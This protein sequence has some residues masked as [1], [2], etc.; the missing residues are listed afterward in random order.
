[1][2]SR[3]RSRGQIYAKMT[4]D[5]IDTRNTQYLPDCGSDLCDVFQVCR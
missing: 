5:V 3:L 1:M 4:E 2:C